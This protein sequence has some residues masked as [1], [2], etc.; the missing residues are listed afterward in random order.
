[1]TKSPKAAV[2][3]VEIGDRK[4]YYLIAGEVVFQA[5]EEEAPHAV[6]ANG[7]VMSSDGKF[8]VPQIAM[9][10]QTLQHIFYTRLGEEA[11]NVKIVD[12]VILGIMPLGE[13]TPAEFNKPV[14][15]SQDI[16]NPMTQRDEGVPVTNVPVK[17]AAKIN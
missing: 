13:F 2:Q 12:V 10:Q 1:M 4:M 6:R 17:Q 16:P 11:K 9:A 3:N 14:L 5:N 8:A 15:M 7:V